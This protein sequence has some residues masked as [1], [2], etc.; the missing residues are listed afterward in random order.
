MASLRNPKTW[1]PYLN[2]KDCSQGFCSVYCPQ[3]CYIIFPPPPPVASPDSDSGPTFSPLVVA[4]I[5]VLASAFLLVSYYVIVTKY[6]KDRRRSRREQRRAEEM[7]SGIHQAPSTVPEWWHFTANNGLD[8]ALIKMITVCEYARGDGLVE[9][10]ECSVCLSEFEEG[11]KL[12]LLPKCSHAFHLPCID[13][14]LESHSNCPLCRANI[15]CVGTGATQGQPPPAEADSSV[16]NQMEPQEGNSAV[17]EDGERIS[18]GES[19]GNDA[20]LKGLSG[21]LSQTA[22]D[23]SGVESGDRDGRGR[24]VKRSISM[25][26]FQ[27]SNADALRQNHEENVLGSS[28]CQVILAGYN[29]SKVPHRAQRP[30]SMKRSF[31]SGIFFENKRGRASN[32]TVIPF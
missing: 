15:A 31:S 18:D 30:T 17:G 24:P 20:G 11:E 29:G 25:G 16:Q 23:E 8:E 10:T 7:E 4:I 2:T 28:A 21:T 19:G 3:W 6:C 14:W 1:A 13:M 27:F 5:G 9:G 12:R 22:P 32:S 26:Y